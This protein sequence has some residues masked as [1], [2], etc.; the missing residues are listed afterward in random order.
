M[1]N[2]PLS[3]F[4]IL[5]RLRVTGWHDTPRHLTTTTTTPPPMPR[6]APATSSA[7]T[8]PRDQSLFR[9]LAGSWW[10]PRAM[11]ALHA[12]N[13]LRVPLI[14]D[15]RI[16]HHF[17]GQ[18]AAQKDLHNAPYPLQN[19]RIL[20]VGC[21]GGILSEAL[22]RLGGE[23]T[24]IDVVEENVQTARQHWEQRRRKGADTVE[25]ALCG[26]QAIPGSL[27]YQCTTVESFAVLHPAAFDMV[28]CSEVIEH[29]ADSNSFLDGVCTLIRPGGIV[30]F[31]TINRTLASFALAIVAG[32]YV[33]RFIPRGTHQ[34][35]KFVRVEE[36]QRNLEK[37]GM[38]VRLTQGM[39]YNPL[40][41]EWRWWASDA[42]VYALV[43]VKNG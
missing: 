14:R 6:T 24:G 40:T 18:P 28:V 16:A 29:V 36:L 25:E 1:D 11:P 43:A 34:W 4:R 30:V 22:V 37:R 15:A 32:E 38:D 31:T 20:D 13:A 3:G 42:V 33:C 19:T 21:G 39:A 27:S 23:V 8:D 2:I 12:M 41:N 5:R 35:G 7:S 10:Q 17:R 26:K 9:S